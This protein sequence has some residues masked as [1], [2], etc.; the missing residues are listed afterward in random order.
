MKRTKS[1]FKVLC[2]SILSMVLVVQTLVLI[3]SPVKA[4][5]T[6]HTVTINPNT[7]VQDDF[8]GVGVNIIPASFMEGT[9]QYGYNEAHWE[10]DKKRIKAIQPKV[11]RVWFQIDWMEPTKG[12]YT[13]NSP[14]MLLFYKY[15]DVLQEAGTEIEFNFGWKNGTSVQSWFSIPGVDARISAPADLDA[16]ANST[17]AVLNELII[18]RGYTNIKY[19]TFYNEPNGNWDFESLGDQKAYFATMVQKASDKLTADGLRSLVEIWGPEESGDPSWTQYM[20]DNADSYFDAYTFHLYGQSYDGLSTSIASRKNVVGNKPVVLTEF[21]FGEDNLSGWNGGLANSVIKSANEGVKGALIWQLNGVWLPDPYVGNDT[22]GN[23]TLWDSIV[24]GT[25]PYKRFYES[26]LLTRY[27]PAHS[28]VVSVNTGSSDLRAAAFKTS[29]GDYT[30]VLETKEGSSKNVTFDFSGVNTGKTFYKH[31]YKSN[32]TLEG[33]AIIPR[34]IA[35]FPAGTS[36]TDTTIDA[37]YNVIVYTTLPS[38]TQVEI[39]PLE[40]IVTGGQTV[41]LQA[42]VI[43]NTGGVTWSVIGSGNGSIT[44]G[45]LYTAP[46]VTSE[47]LITVKA[48]SVNDPDGYGI[49]LVKVRPAPTTNRVTIPELSLAYGKYPSAEAV[50]ITT[51]TAGATIRYTTDGST[52]TSSSQAYT[53]PIFLNSGTKR[54]K[55]IAFKSG[56]NPSA[57]TYSLY[58]IADASIG[59][60]GYQFCAYENGFDCDFTGTASVAYGAEGLFNYMT[61]SNGTACNT[62]VFGDPNPGKSKRCYY[63]YDIPTETPVVTIYNAGFETPGT[64]NYKAGPFTNGWMFSAKSGVQVNGGQ[65]GAATAPAGVQ[66]AYLQSLNGV[67]G[68]ISQ[69]L[70]FQA[71][72]YTISF[73]AAKRTSYGGT[74][75]FDVYFDAT[76]VGS[77]EPTSGSFTSYT[78]NSFTATAGYHTIKF[79]GTSPSGDNTDFIDAVTIQLVTPPN[80][81]TIVIANDGFET[82]SVTSYLKGPMTHGWTFNGKAGV[83]KNGGAFGAATAPEGVQTAFLQSVN[84]VHGEISQAI[85]FDAGTYTLSFEAAKRTTSGGTQSFEVYYDTTLIGSYTPTSGSFIDYTT[86][87]FTATPGNHTIKFIGTSITGDNTDF[88]D[89]VTIQLVTPPNPSTIVIANDGFETPSVS[90]Y[91]KG[92]M[93]HGWTFNDKAGVQKNGGAFGAAAA[94]EGVQT[95]F[96]Q[97]VNG[98][99]GEISQ[100]IAFDVGTYSLSFEAAKRTTSGGTQS[101]DVFYDATLIG[102]YTP[103][104]GSFIAYTTNNFTATA[105]NHTI[106]FVGTSTSGDNTDFIDAVTIQ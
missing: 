9:S 102:S 94:P 92:P 41:Q 69:S 53:G 43:D 87:N 40:P 76:I 37:E 7:V 36:F 51:S 78:T 14:K 84:G 1:A 26:S 30:I 70:N 64:T 103:I 46:N 99:H 90:S 96:L 93:T 48:A 25:K 73:Q 44:S 50:T 100:S 83:Q 34:A 8:L 24:L 31:V 13:W 67:H 6:N 82:P 19:L 56:L 86:N 23:Y 3:P 58:K 38:E 32:V 28:S 55:A 35:S 104:S 81:S 49:A 80:P 33:N 45:G 77:Y 42:N 22:N 20:Y 95:A 98:V 47:A 11:A 10:M 63:N 89:A 75:S 17:S 106:K 21:G 71:G 61:L 18:N 4:S 29:G 74:Q 54:V 65:F 66:T 68:Q 101:F 15:L 39:T 79:V 57:V 27:I 16:Y 52:P 97:S 88:I 60:D 105:G 59:P 85:A 91:L 72:T 5:T 62:S 2:M 12:T